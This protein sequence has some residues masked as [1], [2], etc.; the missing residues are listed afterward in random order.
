MV[1]R[2]ENSLTD[3][4]TLYAGLWGGSRAGGGDVGHLLLQ[5]SELVVLRSVGVGEEGGDADSITQHGVQTF[6]YDHHHTDWPQ[7]SVSTQG[8]M[9]VGN[10]AFL[11]C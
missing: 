9:S 8:K 1:D 3:D 7:V 2:L 5:L 4:V 10:V 11:F 6:H